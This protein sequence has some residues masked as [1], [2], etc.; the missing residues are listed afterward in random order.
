MAA[1]L[2]AALSYLHGVGITHADVKPSN[3][4]CSPRGRCVLV[5]LGL[6]QLEEDVQGEHVPEDA[7]TL[8]YTA[9]EVLKGLGH[10]Q[11]IDWKYKLGWSRKKL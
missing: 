10:D 11:T 1:Q 2:V 3:V 5:D 9:P 7:G 4:I 8:E 6:A